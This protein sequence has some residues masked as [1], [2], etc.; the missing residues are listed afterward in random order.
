MSKF[1]PFYPLFFYHRQELVFLDNEIVFNEAI[2][3]E[4]DQGIQEVQ[5]QITEVN[6][7]FKDLAVLVHDQGAMI[8]MWCDRW[9]ICI[10]MHLSNNNNNNQA[11]YSQ[12][13]WGRLEM[14]PHEQKKTGTKQKWKEGENKGQ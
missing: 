7:I 13:S 3:E 11:F 8:G 5:H 10:L 6:E 14:K 9:N 4:R 2:I 1:E 12:A